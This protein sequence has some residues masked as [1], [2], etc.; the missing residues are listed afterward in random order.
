MLIRQRSWSEVVQQPVR[1][2]D[3]RAMGQHRRFASID[4]GSL[5]DLILER[6]F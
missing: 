3:Q 4:K 5:I 2:L 1:F 6:H